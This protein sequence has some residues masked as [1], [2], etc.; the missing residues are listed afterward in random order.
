MEAGLIRSRPAPARQAFRTFA[1]D[2]ESTFKALAAELRRKSPGQ[3]PD[4]REDYHALI[5]AGD[6]QVER[7]VLVNVEADRVTNT[8]NTLA[9]EILGPAKVSV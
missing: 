8:L 9:E 6:P 3:L 1:A 7:Y 5:A 2:V 4:L